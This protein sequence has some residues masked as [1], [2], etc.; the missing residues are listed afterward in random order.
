LSHGFRLFFAWPL[1][2]W[3]A[4]AYLHEEVDRSCA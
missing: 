4:F 2:E 1:D 3:F